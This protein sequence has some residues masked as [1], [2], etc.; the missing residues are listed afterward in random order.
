MIEHF[1]LISEIPTPHYKMLRNFSTSNPSLQQTARVPTGIPD[2]GVENVSNISSAASTN[3]NVQVEYE[4]SV[5]VVQSFRHTPYHSLWNLNQC[6]VQNA[7]SFQHM[8][9]MMDS[10]ILNE[11]P[12]YTFT[13]ITTTHR[14]T[15]T[16]NGMNASKLLAKSTANIATAAS[17]MNNNNNNAT[18]AS[19]LGMNGGLRQS[20][21]SKVPMQ[22]PPTPRYPQQ[23]A[24][25]TTNGNNQADNRWISSLRRRDPELQPTLPSINNNHNNSY[26]SNGSAS[27]AYTL[28]KRGRSSKIS[29]TLRK[30]RSIE[31]VR[32]R[33]MKLKEKPKKSSS[34]E[35]EDDPEAT[36][37]EENSTNSSPK[38]L[39]TREKIK[40]FNSSGYESHLVDSLEKDILQRNPSIQWNHVA[41]LNEAKAILQEAVVLPVIMPEFFKGIRR[42]WKGILM[43]GPPGT[44]KT[45]LAKAVATECGTTFFNVSSSTLTSK[46]RGES[47]KLVR[48][49]FEM[50][51][52]HAPST[53]FIDEI[54]SLCANR[55]TDTEHEASRRFKAELLIQMDGL[56]E[57]LGDDKI[58]MVLAATN[59]PWDIDE[60]FRRRFEKRIFI[61]LPNEETR[62]ALLSLCLKGVNLSLNLDTKA[63]SDQL[64][65]FTGS[66]ITNVCRDAAMMSMRRKITGRSPA[67]IK[68]IRRE[69]VDLPVTE[70]DFHDAML[71]T[72]KSVSVGDIAKFQ[73]WMEEY[74]SC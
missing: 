26:N 24:T 31:R 11:F 72:R 71:R 50:A 60:A 48:L 34:E 29:P 16:N 3:N 54:D 7:T 39:R 61:G 63:I 13:K 65:G 56:N 19:A 14:P 12:P 62:T 49:L 10:L 51:R 41:G 27:I 43:V 23:S 47:E 64:N 44:G 33:K 38:G 17:N 37:I 57:S 52:F 73:K 8:A 18:V 53:I 70:Q 1:D 46:Y 74:G 32:A 45:M 21:K 30:S 35:N 42:P 68:Q 67:E 22:V 9:R 6:N 2:G 20:P 25:H 66:D 58:I 69:E 5:P 40:V 55:G 4:V 59:H 28:D 15:R 36:S